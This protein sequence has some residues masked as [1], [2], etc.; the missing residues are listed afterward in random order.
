MGIYRPRVSIVVCT[1]E[2]ERNNE[3]NIVN[4][5][6]KLDENLQNTDHEVIISCNNPEML[7]LLGGIALKMTI[8]VRILDNKG[9]IGLPAA[10]DRGG[11]DANGEYIFFLNQD[12][13][14]TRDDDIFTEMIVAGETYSVGVSKELGIFGVEASDCTVIRGTHKF[15]DRYE[16]GQFHSV[17]EVALSGGFLY[18]M[19]REVFHA[20]NGFDLNI[21][22]IFFEEFDFFKKMQKLEKETGVRYANILIP[23][24]HYKHV[25]GES[26]KN[27]FTNSITWVHPETYEE[28]TEM[29]AE[30]HLRNK[31]YLEKKWN[32]KIQAII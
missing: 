8:N 27:P 7:P 25:F 14:L 32:I 10:W 4:L 1:H 13:I 9:N 6:A 29:L 30:I 28:K 15:V 20:I 2:Y 26:A 21:S 3:G 31:A 24:I 11:R 5:L 18:G 19:N 17:V 12:V 23:G 22:P 16:S